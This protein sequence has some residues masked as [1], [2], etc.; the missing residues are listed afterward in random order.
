M[1]YFKCPTCRTLLADKQLLYEREHDKLCSDSK[2]DKKDL[3]D[4]KKKLL[5]DLGLWRSCCRMRMISYC[6]LIDLIN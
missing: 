3:D 6:K 5:D 2:M 1:L 4:A